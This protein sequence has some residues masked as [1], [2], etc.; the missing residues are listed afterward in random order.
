MKGLHLMRKSP[1]LHFCSWRSLKPLR[2]LLVIAICLLTTSCR[3]SRAEVSISPEV[4]DTE[5]EESAWYIEIEQERESGLTLS[6]R[7]VVCDGEP[8]QFTIKT[9]CPE[10]TTLRGE[11]WR[12]SKETCENPYSG[13]KI[14]EP[15]GKISDLFLNFERQKIAVLEPVVLWS[16]H[17]LD[18]CKDG[19]PRSVKV[20]LFPPTEKVG[21]WLS[22]D[23]WADPTY[24]LEKVKN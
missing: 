9:Q 21:L 22:T 1:Q 4:F 18:Q 6:H 15:S 8:A 23:Y 3:W 12:I 24:E 14:V 16:H 17:S 13:G 20:E 19:T 10:K 11:V 2:I 5:H 7:G